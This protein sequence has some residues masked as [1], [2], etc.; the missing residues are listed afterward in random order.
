MIALLRLFSQ[1]TR[2]TFE[3]SSHQRR[4]FSA[5]GIEYLQLWDPD[6][7]GTSK[8]LLIEVSVDVSDICLS[9]KTILRLSQSKKLSFT[10]HIL[11]SPILEGLLLWTVNL[12]PPHTLDVWLLVQY[13]K[14]SKVILQ[15]I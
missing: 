5:T 2:N 12:T 9:I 1:K 10:W 13:R 4:N 8:R 14:V 11:P 7:F 15:S 3:E 6:L